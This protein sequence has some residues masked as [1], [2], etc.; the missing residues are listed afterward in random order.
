MSARLL[1]LTALGVTTLA[2][3]PS[4]RGAPGEAAESAPP[5]APLVAPSSAPVASAS[6]AAPAPDER[7]T[8]PPV[9]PG[10]PPV[11]VPGGKKTTKS[12]TGLVVSVDPEASRLGARVLEA[13]GN[14][15]DA[16]VAV[17]FVLA[18]THPSAGNL[19]GGGFMLIRPKAGP[20]TAIDFRET[21]PREL[22]R[23]AFQKMIAGG[24]IGPGSV[25]VPGTVR[26]LAL[27]HERLGKL[28]WRQCVEPARRLAERGH[29]I[30]SREAQTI[31]W[32]WRAL[33]RDAAARA[34]FGNAGKPRQ[35]KDL[36]VRKQLATVLGRIAEH[37]AAGFYEG[38]TARAIADTLAK[39]GGTLGTE[40]LAAYRAKLRPPLELSYRGLSV[41]TMPPPSA[42]GVALLET[43][44]MLE[45][46]SA[47]KNPMG[48]AADAH[49]FL[50]ASRRAQADRRYGV[51]DPD[52]IA[53]GVLARKLAGFRDVYS[54][55]QRVPIDAE[56]ATPTDKVRALPNG[57]SEEPE[58]TTHF[59]VVDA[60][61]LAVSCTTTLSAGFGSK[62]VVPG[63]GVVLNNSVASFSNVGENQ[64]VG[65]HRTVSSM[66]PTLV[67]R[68]GELLLVLGS[69]GGD[70]IPS[71]VAQVFRHLVDHG[72]PLD[73]AVD[74]GR[75]HHNFLPDEFRI[76]RAR[77]PAKSTLEALKRMGHSL[78]KKTLPM[79][80]ANN[81]AIVGGL[82]Y[83]YAD[84][85]E[86]GQAVAARK[87][88]P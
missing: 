3:T 31:A 55:L 35:E 21:A 14:A 69:P 25:G 46:E 30:R 56:H 29:R 59:S 57:A 34:E 60:D 19:G 66:A 45:R 87:T 37:G 6:A 16:A 70:T 9:D 40:D 18:V 1:L 13:G 77:P 72:M 7:P 42:G 79:G 26:G 67:T 86:G 51:V 81:L 41:E 76:E 22:P 38:E 28:A 61:G 68:D 62:L 54:L 49:L 71:T 33:S 17:A 85:R 50:E 52:S 84:P 43:L 12:A 83:G 44:L 10:P 47:Y 53:P 11:L 80:D 48:S 78:S 24:G 74:A 8:P 23:A 75:L 88:S 27:A 63:T 36:W 15:V 5:R 4:P 39:A 65:G 2:C 64:P 32:N 20:T 82:A 73:A 58:H